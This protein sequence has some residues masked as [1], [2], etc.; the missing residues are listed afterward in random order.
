MS[1]QALERQVTP[2]E[3]SIVL[4]GSGVQILLIVHHHPSKR[5]GDVQ[6]HWKCKWLEFQ[7]RMWSVRGD[8]MAIASEANPC[9]PLSRGSWLSLFCISSRLFAR[10]TKEKTRKHLKNFRKTQKDHEKPSLSCKFRVHGAKEWPKKVHAEAGK[11]L[12]ETPTSKPL[13]KFAWDAPPKKKA[14]FPTWST[15]W[16]EV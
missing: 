3:F 2:A 6:F 10:K 9:W 14:R 16:F 1:L 5:L 13:Q 11:N 4:P 8:S 7:I 15:W 12:S